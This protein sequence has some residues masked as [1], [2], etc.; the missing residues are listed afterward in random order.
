MG[1]KVFRPRATCVRFAA[2]ERAHSAHMWKNT[3]LGPHVQVLKRVD[4]LIYA[5]YRRPP[6]GFHYTRFAAFAGARFILAPIPKLRCAFNF[7]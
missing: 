6:W 1:Q 2:R 4:V 3:E 7:E 5:I